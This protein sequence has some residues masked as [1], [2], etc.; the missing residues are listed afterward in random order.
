MR[1]NA[2]ALDAMQNALVKIFMKLELFNANF[3]SFKS[4]SSKIVSNECIMY[5]RKYWKSNFFQELNGDENCISEQEN[6][7]S[8]LTAQEMVKQIQKLPDGYRLI[9]NMYAMEGYSHK[10]IAEKLGIS[11]GTSKSQ[12]FKA[13]KILKREIESL[14][15]IEKYA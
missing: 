8:S 12:L 13:K 4:W 7:I 10:E 5:Q 9:F 3:G 15:N 14:F 11:I 1:N 2:D 6:P